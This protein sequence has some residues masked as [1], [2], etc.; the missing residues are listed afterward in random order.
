MKK[1]LFGKIIGT[2]GA[3]IALFTSAGVYVVTKFYFKLAFERPKKPS[4]EDNRL[5]EQ[6]KKYEPRRQADSAW[7]RALSSG[8]VECKSFDGLT[9]KAHYIE[10]PNAVRTIILVHGWHGFWD[11][12]FASETKWLYENGCNM[13]AIEQR[14]HGNS[15]GKYVTFGLYERFDI[16]SWAKWLNE[17]KNPQNV[18][19]YGKSMG[20]STVLMAGS[21]KDLPDNIRGIIEDCGYSD[22]YAEIVYVGS[23]SGLAEHPFCDFL[24]AMV[25]KKIKISLKDY[26]PLQAVR[27]YTLPLLI[28]HGKGDKFVPAYMANEIYN[29]CASEKKLVLIDEAEHCLSFLLDK[30]TYTKELLEL[31]KND[32]AS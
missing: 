23:K 13:V 7:F 20:A 11:R 1:N 8:E 18:Y 12:E 9:L 28:F 24:N 15:E 25:K 2:A 26:S 17:N 4:G 3:G 5:T 10:A 19:L 14:G 32:C 31:F 16:V 29:A 21:D 6:E 22:P 27:K 30:D